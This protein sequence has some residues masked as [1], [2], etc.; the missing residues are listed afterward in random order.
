MRKMQPNLCLALLIA[1]FGGAAMAAHVEAKKDGVEVYADATNKSTV[2][3]T[4]KAG[5]S[6][7]AGERKGMFWAI[8]TSDGKDGFV[9]VLSVKHKPDSD[10]GIAGAIKAA[11]KDG[12][13]D[14][15]GNDARAR[16]A[17]MGVRGLADDDNMAN[18]SNVRP[19]LRAVYLME[20][21][22]VSD[23]KIEELGQSVLRE[24]AGKAA[25]D[26]PSGAAK[27]PPAKSE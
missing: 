17:V 13:S 5:D 19:N 7:L 12:R 26:T 23:K 1:T 4:L 2:V 24:I 20:D 21:K 8:K 27:A 10:G 15:D 14:G 3:T 25:H 22:P 9:S 6:V 11:S 16:S 18:A